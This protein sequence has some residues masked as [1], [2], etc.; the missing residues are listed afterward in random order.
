MSNL[1]NIYN[2]A[3]GPDGSTLLAKTAGA[4]AKVAWGVLSEPEATQNH[5][6][7]VAWAKRVLLDPVS[8]ARRMLWAVL[9]NATVQ[10]AGAAVEDNDLERVV[11]QLVDL[12]SAEG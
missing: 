5:A 2:L 1:L 6:K 11:G 9:G 4:V 8:E 12:F 7:R 10:S 3:V